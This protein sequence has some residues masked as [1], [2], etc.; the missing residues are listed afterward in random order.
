MNGGFWDAEEDR[1]VLVPGSLF[2]LFGT[3]HF[4][5]DREIKINFLYK[6]N[7]NFI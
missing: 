4:S 2:F 6:K 1:Y 7:F 3:I 5:Y